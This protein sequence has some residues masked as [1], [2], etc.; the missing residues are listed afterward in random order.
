MTIDSIFLKTFYDGAQ[1]IAFENERI[2]N[3]MQKTEKKC[4]KK[5]LPGGEG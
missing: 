4:R 1:F 2:G 5:P 3:V